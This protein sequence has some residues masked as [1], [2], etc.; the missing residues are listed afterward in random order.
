MPCGRKS[1]DEGVMEHESRSAPRATGR[2]PVR[3]L[4]SLRRDARPIM[5]ALPG[6]GLLLGF[7]ARFLGFGGA[8]GWIWVVASLPVLLLLLVE[9][10]VSLR[11]GDVGLDI[12]AA[13]SMTAA[14][15]FGENRVS[16]SLQC[17]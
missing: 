6:A 8:S 2:H 16:A 7:A 12:V 11:R 17:A 1:G 10:A 14:I 15:A 3:T 5:V 4:D 9:I 13:L